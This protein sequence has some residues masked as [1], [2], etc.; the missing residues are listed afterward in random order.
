MIPQ[1]TQ[2][3]VPLC[4]TP[5]F[6]ADSNPYKEG[7][8]IT[9]R[10]KLEVCGAVVGIREGGS[11]PLDLRSGVPLSWCPPHVWVPGG[12][13]PP[14][15][16]PALWAGPPLSTLHTMAS[17]QQ[18]AMSSSGRGLG[19]GMR[20]AATWSCRQRCSAS[21][22][23]RGATSDSPARPSR[24]CPSASRGAFTLLALRTGKPHVWQK[25][26]TSCSATSVWANWS[27][28]EQGVKEVGC[29][30]GGRQAEGPLQSSPSSAPSLPVFLST[31]RV[32]F[33]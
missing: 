7:G 21:L 20:P 25:A 18:V 24:D 28:M 27:N 1:I 8:S 19:G 4:L 2:P 30:G 22:F 23:R 12:L 3:S 32:P 17:S 29:I 33:P 11:L 5:L 13:F 26:A 6:L 31:C 10:H 15:D 16:P 9:P 14:G